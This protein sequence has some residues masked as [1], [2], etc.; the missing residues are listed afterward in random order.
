[1][2]KI[3]RSVKNV[4]KGYSQVEVKVRNGMEC[5][6][7]CTYGVADNRSNQQRPMGTCRV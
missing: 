1:M 4:T 7:S 3:A 2:S 6:W 5:P